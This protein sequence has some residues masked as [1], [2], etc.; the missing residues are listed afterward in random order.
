[1]EIL[2][3]NIIQT[4][5]NQFQ[6]MGIRNVSIDDVCAELRISKKTFYRYFNKKEDLV[7]AVIEHDRA[8]HQAKLQKNIKDKNAIEIF[9]CMVKELKNLLNVLPCFF[10]TTWKNSIP[11]CFKN[12][13]KSNKTMS[14]IFLKTILNKVLLKDITGKI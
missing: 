9:V 3:E 1:M 2:K 14:A 12:T 7:D 11:L 8:L 13:T 5:N 10:G 4:A 6:R